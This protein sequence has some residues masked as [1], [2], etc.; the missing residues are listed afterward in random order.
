MEAVL[1]WGDAIDNSTDADTLAG[2]L[3]EVDDSTIPDFLLWVLQGTLS[4]SWGT[5]CLHGLRL[6]LGFGLSCG[7]LDVLNCCGMQKVLLGLLVAT[8]IESMG[9]KLGSAGGTEDGKGG[10]D[11]LHNVWSRVKVLPSTS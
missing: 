1:S 2:H 10:N 9:S 7:S 11:L 8:R 3:R 4:E 5:S 6:G